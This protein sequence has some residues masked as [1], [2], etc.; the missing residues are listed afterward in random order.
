[1]R[2]LF[3]LTLLI[4]SLSLAEDTGTSLNNL[5]IPSLYAFSLGNN[6]KKNSDDIKSTN[7]DIQEIFSSNGFSNKPSYIYKF[8]D[9][10]NICYMATVMNGYSI[11]CVKGN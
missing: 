1:M 8:T 3:I 7:V 11:S 9:G 10:N 5:L 2:K 4:P 6:T